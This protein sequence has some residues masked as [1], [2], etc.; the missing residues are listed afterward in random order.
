MKEQQATKRFSERAD[1]YSLYRPTYPQDILT[2]LKEQELLQPDAQIVDMGSGTGIFAKLLLEAGYGVTAVEPNAA[3]RQ[4]AE[5]SLGA[6]AG[7]RSVAGTGEATSLPSAST[8]LITVAQAFHW[9]DPL[10]AR[11]E[12]ERLLRAHGAVLLVWNILQADSPFLME[13]TAL[14]AKY[15]H[16]VQHAHRANLARI[17]EIFLPKPVVMGALLHTQQLNATGLKGQLLSSSMIP[18]EGEPRYTEMLTELS[19]L[20]ERYQ[21]DGLVDM[22][23]ETQLFLIKY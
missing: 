13:Y 6:Y 17:E 14:K 16:N 4:L 21:E 18:L 5:A 11:K 2:F 12:F 9:F 20:F 3:M 22:L 15:A 7:F 1:Q 8:D 10:A 23:Y 19:V